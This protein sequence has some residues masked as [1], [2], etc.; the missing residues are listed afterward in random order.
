MRVEAT[1][2]K[3]DVALR[4]PAEDLLLVMW[5][6]RPLDVLDVLGD[7]AVAERLLEVATF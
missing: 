5:R 4:G 3:G 1:H 6:R 7:R 2:A